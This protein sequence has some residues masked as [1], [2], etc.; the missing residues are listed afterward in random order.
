MSSTGNNRSLLKRSD[1]GRSLMKAEAVITGKDL[2]KKFTIHHLK[3]T[4]LKERLLGMVHRK[5]YTRE[6]FWALRD[7]DFEVARG[8]TLGLIGPN[9][10]GKSTLLQ[11]I[12]RIILPD[13]GK[14]TIDG[15]VAALLEL[16]AG[17]NPDLSGRENIFLN[18]SILGFGRREIEA[19]L[20][21]IIAFSEL[22]RFIDTPVRNYSTGMYARLGFSIAVHVDPDILLVDEVLAVGDEAFARKCADKFDLFRQKKKTI[23]IVS[24]DLDSVERLCDRA[25]LLHKGEVVTLGK[26]R[27]AI[28]DYHRL[29][30]RIQRT[31][32]KEE[33]ARRKRQLEAEQP[34]AA[35]GEDGGGEE[36]DAFEA[37]MERVSYSEDRTRWGTG[38][39]TITG[40]TFH[41]ER[42]EE[43]SDFRTGERLVARI[44]YRAEA[45]VSEPVFGVALFD[46]NGV[47][48]NGP[49][50]YFCDYRID[51]IGPGV[52]HMDYVVENLPLLPGKYLFSAAVYRKDLRTPFDH[53]ERSYSF[54]VIEGQVRE[55]LGLV[56][57]ENSWSIHHGDE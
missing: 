1:G 57:L 43:E 37:E 41:N 6:T 25:L 46:R 4:N 49:N 2:S 16:G 19:K 36:A 35:A 42:D 14:V 31:Q 54:R 13:Q 47:Q 38:E 11:L 12:A 22:E 45:R 24:H 27:D 17:F 52:G 32:E 51:R 40:V 20:D 10:S 28:I 7:V 8:E 33:R 21:D 53:R 50:S 56:Q 29:V 9:G 26:P 34:S 48:I 5:N 23:V 44:H 15:R 30:A 55:R 39:V 18:S 3:T